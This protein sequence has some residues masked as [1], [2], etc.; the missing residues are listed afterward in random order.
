MRLNKALRDAERDG[1]EMWDIVAGILTEESIREMEERGFDGL[2]EDEGHSITLVD[3]EWETVSGKKKPSDVAKRKGPPRPQKIVV[4]DIRQRH[5]QVQSPQARK[6]ARDSDFPPHSLV[7]DPWTQISSL[8]DHVSTLLPPHPPSIFQSFFHS[9][10]Y[11]TSY[12]ALRAALTSLCQNSDEDATDHTTVTFNLLDLVM[13]QYE[14]SDDIHR[15]RIVSDV[16]LAVVVTKGAGDE[17]LQ[18]IDLLREL[19][20]NADLGI[21]HQLPPPAWK[22]DTIESPTISRT[23]P[24]SC[25]PDIPPPPSPRAKEKP[26]PL[27]ATR[28]KPSPYQWQA[29]PQKKVAPK[30][31]HPLSHHIPAY[32]R[33][34]NGMKTTRAFGR[35]GGKV[36][37]E[38]SEFQRRMNETMKKR[39]DAL[40]EATRM[41]QKGNSKTRGGEVA[42][43]FAERVGVDFLECCISQVLTGVQARELQEVARQ[44]GLSAARAMVHAKRYGKLLH[45]SAGC[46]RNAE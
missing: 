29:V 44:E 42:F 4:A 24:P 10:K 34:V 40:R 27:A 18:L 28:N 31:P 14:I 39:N 20:S 1:V 12:D 23:R 35:K 45:S 16:Q 9:P 21:Y 19:D 41:W 26:P 46:S 3:N 37:V 25:P 5:Q 43:Y 30:G 2:E 22:S 6:S 32:T 11:T 38:A 33:D 8:S 15:S 7:A 36:D 17:A 13:P